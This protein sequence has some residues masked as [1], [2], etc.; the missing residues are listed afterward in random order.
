MFT[1]HIDTDND[2]F[3]DEPATEIAR[4]LESL[5]KRVRDGETGGRLRDINGNTVGVFR[6]DDRG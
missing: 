4:I 6:A 3:V 5:A 1:L 2:A